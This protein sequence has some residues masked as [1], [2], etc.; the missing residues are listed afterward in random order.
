M[1]CLAVSHTFV[2]GGENALR[3]I[4][5]KLMLEKLDVLLHRSWGASPPQL[6]RRSHVDTAD[7]KGLCGEHNVTA[8]EDMHVQPRQ[9]PPEQSCGVPS[10]DTLKFQFGACCRLAGPFA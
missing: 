4:Q 1:L 10:C 7:A 8:C 9:T 5:R 3:L 2:S 6:A